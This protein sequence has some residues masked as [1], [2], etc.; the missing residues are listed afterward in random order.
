MIKLTKVIIKGKKQCV[1]TVAVPRPVIGNN[2]NL[3]EYYEIVGESRPLSGFFSHTCVF[4]Y[5]N[6]FLLMKL[7]NPPSF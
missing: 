6:A 7:S 2:T 4:V 5:R 3:K 1:A